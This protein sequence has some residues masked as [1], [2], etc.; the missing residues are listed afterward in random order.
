M[1][2][3]GYV[4]DKIDGAEEFIDREIVEPVKELFS[5]RNIS[6]NE[7]QPESFEQQFNFNGDWHSSANDRTETFSFDGNW[8][9]SQ[10]HQSDNNDR[11]DSYDDN[12]DFLLDNY[13]QDGN[14]DCF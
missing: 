2:E 10:K 14:I 4:E 12:S 11:D 5:D 8:Y 6:Q 13:W 1:T 7:T 3:E 9:N